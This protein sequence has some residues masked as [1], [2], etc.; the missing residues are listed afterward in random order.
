[1]QRF[2]LPA[3]LLAAGSLTAQTVNFLSFNGSTGAKRNLYIVGDGFT[4]AEQNT[5]N[6][7]VDTTILQGVFR[8]GDALAECMNAFNIIRINADSTHSG[9]TR[10]DQNG[11]V[12]TARTTYLDY[13]YSGIW[14]RCWM[15]PGPR[16]ASALDSLKRTHAPWADYWV[17]VL[18]ETGF[19]GCAR[20]NTIAVTRAVDWTVI[21]HELGHM[22]GGLGDEYTGGTASYGGGEP[23]A[24]NLSRNGTRTVKWNAY[25][26]P[27]TPVP[28]VP[29]QVA[30]QN[31]DVGVFEGATL[32]TT[33]Y[34]YG[35]FRPVA[36]CRM[37]GNAPAFCPVC[38]EAL[39]DALRGYDEGLLWDTVVGDF[40]GDGRDDVVLHG[41]T[42]LTL[43]TS[44]GSRLAIAWIQTMTQH[45]HSHSRVVATDFSGDGRADLV[46]MSQQNAELRMF[47]STGAGFTLVGS[48]NGAF[49]EWALQLYD[50][51][52]FGD[53]NGDGKRDVAIFNA[54][55]WGKPLLAFFLSTGSSWV[56]SHWYYDSIPGWGLMRPNDKFLVADTNGDRKDDLY[57]FNGVDW[58][59]TYLQALRSTG[60]SLQAGPLYSGTVPGWSLRRNDRLLVADFDADQRDDLYVFNAADWWQPYLGLV[61]SDGY[62]LSLTQGYGGAVP[63]WGALKGGDM[64]FAADVNGDRRED[65]YVYNSIDYGTNRYLGMLRSSGSSLSGT[66]QVNAIGRWTMGIIDLPQ[67]ANF[68]G[69]AMVDLLVRNGTMLT[70]L[71]SNGLSVS[72]VRHYPKYIRNVRYHAMGWW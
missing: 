43:Y 65:L 9:V 40:N 50:S 30:D 56:L 34:R 28:T 38:Y 71:A 62:A 37:N 19:G 46:V 70:M 42:S 72:G 8:N 15:E 68:N 24:P 69:G 5:F 39:R 3:A 1:M 51:F 27:R 18:N 64:F 33:N 20:G 41:G 12:V 66:Y 21:A 6:Q 35:L 7:Y 13:R 45:V 23:G 49:R 57:A 67:I 44:D 36:D 10:V 63:G 55:Q 29:T 47:Q 25:I 22:V 11:T 53:W 16:T 58:S 48:Y 31:R 54:T 59:V 17:I 2:L 26:D 14:S 4:S 52:L 61:R 32:G 60:T